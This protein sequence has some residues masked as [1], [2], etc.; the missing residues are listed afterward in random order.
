MIEEGEKARYDEQRFI[1]ALNGVDLDKED[2][3][4]I[5]T[6]APQPKAKGRKWLFGDPKEYDKMS[7]E[8]KRVETERIK[9]TIKK[10]SGGII[11]LKETKVKKDG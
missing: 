4:A 1:A 10:L 11:P 9:E 3:E 5:N 7:P 2:S 8:E 6:S